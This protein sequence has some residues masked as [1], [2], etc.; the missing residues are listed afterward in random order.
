LD[1]PPRWDHGPSPEPSEIVSDAGDQQELQLR[2]RQDLTQD[3]DARRRIEESL[4]SLPPS[5]F[6]DDLQTRI[7]AAFQSTR[8]EQGEFLPKGLLCTL[9]NTQSVA[10]ELDQQLSDI[11]T[12]EEI[13]RYAE[14][15]CSETEVERRGKL[16]IK[17][18]RKIFALL[19]LVEATKFILQFLEEDVSDID[20]PLTL[21]KY[22]GID[23]LCRRNTTGQDAGEPLKCLRRPKWSTTK[24][25]LFEYY[26]WKVL[27]PF[28]FQDENG[29]V[30]HYKLNDQHILPFM[31]L[32]DMAEEDAEREGGFGRVQMVGIHPDHHNFRA[33]KSCGRGFAVKQQIYEEHRDSFKKE[34]IILKKFSGVRSHP[35][36]VSLLATYE[37]FKKF[38]LIFYRAEGD[39]FTYWKE[40]RSQPKINQRNVLWVA[41]QCRGIVDGLLKL[42]RLLTLPK[43]Q[44]GAQE[45]PTQAI[46]G[47]LN[48]IC[49]LSQTRFSLRCVHVDGLNSHRRC[50][51]QSRY[52]APSL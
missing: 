37:Q 6:Y 26:Q 46:R 2:H 51:E 21:V 28:F 18:F 40:L 14:R 10:Q 42:H 12:P 22:K 8:K 25:R 7:H 34:I 5:D 52:F 32:D 41:E 29:D 44:G 36:V 1:P 33:E 17:S 30:K 27:A 50:H 38:H 35:H 9:I 15:I 24:L 3:L 43:S 49:N 16:K 45:E 31:A 13:S 47:T 23:G 19:V 48:H 11:H 20:L 39:L 4:A